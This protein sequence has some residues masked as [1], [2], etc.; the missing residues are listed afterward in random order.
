[1]VFAAVTVHAVVWRRGSSSSPQSVEIAAIAFG[2]LAF[3]ERLKVRHRFTLLRQ[4]Q[5]RLPALVGF[6]I[7]HLC[8]RGRTTHFAQAEHLHLKITAVVLHL[9]QVANSNL[10]RSFSRLSV[11]VNSAEFTG[12]AGERARLEEPGGP[13]PLVYSH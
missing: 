3:P 8:H 13:K 11:G 1:M 4:F 9:Q 7:E 12:A 2:R 6:P 5:P 10:A